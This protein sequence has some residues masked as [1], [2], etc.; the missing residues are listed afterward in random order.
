VGDAVLGV[1][2]VLIDRWPA[3]VDVAL[4]ALSLWWVVALARLL[5]NLF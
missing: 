5:G 1:L 4:V 3:L 2:L